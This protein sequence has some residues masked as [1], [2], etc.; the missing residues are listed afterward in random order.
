VETKQLLLVMDITT[1][2]RDTNQSSQETGQE[3]K[4]QSRE[5][6]DDLE[7]NLLEED[8]LE[9]DLLEEEMSVD[10]TRGQQ[11]TKVVVGVIVFLLAFSSMLLSKLSFASLA[12]DMHNYS[13]STAS[14]NVPCTKA[15]SY[16]R[17]YWVVFTPYAICLFRCAW[18]SLRKPRFRFPWPSRR[19]ILKVR[20]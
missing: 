6:E 11:V 3:A 13:I 12:A 16:W 9:E 14:E 18:N 20:R 5:M 7:E 8:L 2:R 1:R 19:L 4:R 10:R 15:R 17:M